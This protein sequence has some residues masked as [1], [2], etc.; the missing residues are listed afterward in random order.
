MI[1][2][3][4]TWQQICSVQLACLILKKMCGE[5]ENVGLFLKIS[6]PEYHIGTMASQKINIFILLVS[7]LAKW[8]KVINFAS[9]YPIQCT[10]I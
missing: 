6:H 7:K 5:N 3:A 4:S 1:G 10:Y 2:F 9:Q 8:P